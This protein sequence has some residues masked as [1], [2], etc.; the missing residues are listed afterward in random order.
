MQ[1]E[2]TS[3]QTEIEAAFGGF[4]CINAF[5][6]V[7][8]GDD[9][10]FIDFLRKAEVPPRTRVY[11][12]SSGGDVETAIN[13]GRT[14]RDSWF[15]T[16]IGR[17]VLDPDSEGDLIKAR[18][19]IS[20]QCMS[21]ATLLFIGGRLRHLCPE[22]R[23]GVHQFS[24]RD[25]TP[26]H[27]GQSQILSAKIARYIVDMGITPDF[28]SISSA[29]D[30]DKIELVPH[31]DLRR[32][33]F[34][35]GGET[36]VDWSLQSVDNTL[37][38]RG[39]RDNFYGHHKMLF[40]FVKSTGFFVYAVIETQGRE[41]EL[42]NFPLV[43]LVVGMNEKIVIDISYRCNRTINGIYCNI[44]V[45]LSKEEAQEI[46]RSDGFGIRV[47]GGPDAGMFLGVGPMST[48]GGT[49]ILAALFDNLT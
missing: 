2:Y 25:P 23:F 26:A 7:S 36:L 34:V 5:G 40:G 19:K 29:I 33:L 41:W 31:E 28:L 6:S 16:H 32:L 17:Y 47:R 21:A 37:Y 46:V 24:F 39:E 42:T 12:D 14:I 11:I 48:K 10:R 30:A 38:V 15:S 35:T 43:E 9:E 45:F 8:A 3:P 27:I 44:D 4:Y 20:G 49:Q 1:F 22:D 13:M 18:K